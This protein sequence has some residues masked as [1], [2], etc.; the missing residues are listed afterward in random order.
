MNYPY[1]VCLN[2]FF[3]ERDTLELIWSGL[4]H[5][6]AAYL[7][8]AS[9]TNGWWL[10]QFSILDTL[11]PAVFLRHI[12]CSF[13]QDQAD[14]Q[15]KVAW[16]DCHS[17]YRTAPFWLPRST[18]LSISSEQPPWAFLDYYCQPIHQVASVP[19]GTLCRHTLQQNHRW[20]RH[21]SH[22]RYSWSLKFT[23]TLICNIQYF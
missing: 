4:Y 10:H 2:L 22:Q 14:E 7:G 5:A 8:R 23:N 19:Y 15:H 9:S 13:G 6:V 20:R 3:S 18:F 11:N 21:G 1:R 16:Y 17:V 12:S